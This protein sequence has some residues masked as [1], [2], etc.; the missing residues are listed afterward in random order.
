MAQTAAVYLADCW[1]YC[2]PVGHT[3]LIS[4]A[5]PRGWMGFHCTGTVIETKW[6]FIMQETNV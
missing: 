3:G 6:D 2:R 1:S 4:D 5:V